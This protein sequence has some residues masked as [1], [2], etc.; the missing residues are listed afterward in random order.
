M[1]NDNAGYWD[2]WRGGYDA[3]NH[4]SDL[5]ESR[6]ERFKPIQPEGPPTS[7]TLR[8]Q[9]WALAR[10]AEWQALQISTST[11]EAVCA[12]VAVKAVAE[13]LMNGGAPL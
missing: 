6:A 13:K 9:S 7:P 8:P 5:A 10:L 4:C 11:K 3:S 2:G 1:N 12:A